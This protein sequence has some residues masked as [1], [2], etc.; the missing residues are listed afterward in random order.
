[1]GSP[2]TSSLRALDRSGKALT[3][4]AE[5][6][7]GFVEVAVPS[8]LWEQARLECDERTL[9]LS[10]Q[11]VGAARRVVAR[12]QPSGTG[13]YELRLFLPDGSVERITWTIEPTKISLSAY[14][15]MLEALQV[16]LAVSVALGLQRLGALTGL[17]FEEP[18]ES[19]LA[20]E[21]ARLRRA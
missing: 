19:T 4:P 14:F 10:L 21:L 15:Q 18:A 7:Q 6:A 5:W 3:A 13:H 2:A 16:R 8:E 1:M 9:P 20:Q 17:R 11:R 12:W